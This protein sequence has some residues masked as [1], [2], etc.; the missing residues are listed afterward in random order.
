MCPYISHMYWMSGCIA[1]YFFV[2]TDQVQWNTPHLAIALDYIKSTTH[3]P[4]SE[5]PMFIPDT[6]IQP[7]QMN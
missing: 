4:Y 3:L 5:I 1:H 7:A 2:V 6:D